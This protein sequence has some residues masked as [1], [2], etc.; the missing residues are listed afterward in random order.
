MRTRLSGFA[1]SAL[2]ERVCTRRIVRS[3]RFYSNVGGEEVK[4]RHH[5]TFQQRVLQFDTESKACSSC[6]VELVE[7]LAQ[8]RRIRRTKRRFRHRPVQY[9]DSGFAA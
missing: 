9:V 6:S 1:E 3:K 5:R 2:M 7:L 4:R 8:E